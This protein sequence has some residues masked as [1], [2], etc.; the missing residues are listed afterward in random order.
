MHNAEIARVFQDIAD[1]L[2]M[3]GENPFKIRAYHKAARTIDYLPRE[4]A[5]YL[6]EGGDLK[7]AAALDKAVE[8]NANPARMDLKDTHAFLARELRVKLVVSTD[9]HAPSH[10]GLVRY[11]VGVA[12]RA[13]CRAG[14]ILNTR[15][16]ADVLASLRDG[17]G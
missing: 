1:L 2:E 17:H 9:A 7:A 5:S 12:R 15:P 6:E 4:V 3:K 14:D 10:L 11:G 16:A 13:W 8:I